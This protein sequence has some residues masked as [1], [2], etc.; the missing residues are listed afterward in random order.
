[1]NAFFLKALNNQL[2]I[3]SQATQQDDLKKKKF[4]EK[5]KSKDGSLSMATDK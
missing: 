5:K 1:M 3:S 2:N 4:L